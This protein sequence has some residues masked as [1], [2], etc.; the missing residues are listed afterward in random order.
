MAPYDGSPQ[1]RAVRM[2]FLLHLLGIQPDP[3][4][5]ETKEAYEL[6]CGEARRMCNRQKSFLASFA[7]LGLF[8]M[9]FD[10]ATMRMFD[11]GSEQGLLLTSIWAPILIVTGALIFLRVFLRARLGR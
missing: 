11:S 4:P 2:W 9:G 1:R 7:A 5:G 6:R 8:L 3:E 10:Y